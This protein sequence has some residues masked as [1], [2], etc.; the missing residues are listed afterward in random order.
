[1]AGLEKGQVHSNGPVELVMFILSWPL[2]YGKWCLFLPLIIKILN[3]KVL[4]IEWLYSPY[5]LFPYKL[6]KCQTKMHCQI[7]MAA[8]YK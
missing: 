7:K 8:R 6:S 5:Q 3:K 2:P 1:M 4:F